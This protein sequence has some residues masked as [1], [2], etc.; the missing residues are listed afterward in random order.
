MPRQL[1]RTSC[2]QLVRVLRIAA[3]VGQRHSERPVLHLPDV[4]E[5]VCDEVVARPLER[6]PEHDRVPGGVT[7]EA[8]EPGEPEEPG[9]DEDANPVDP[10][11]GWVEVELVEAGL[12]PLEGLLCALAPAQLTGRST[13]TGLPSWS[14]SPENVYARGM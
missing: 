12:R 13:S 5:L 7:V 14:C 1:D 10:H 9:P 4:A 11:P 6:L 2:L 3:E 8:V